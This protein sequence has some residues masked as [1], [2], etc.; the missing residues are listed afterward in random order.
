M[1]GRLQGKRI[2]ITGAGS[3]IGRAAV[4]RFAGEGAEILAIDVDGRGLGETGEAVGGLATCVADVSSLADMERVAQVAAQQ[5]GG[6]DGVYANAGIPAPGN[7]LEVSLKTWQRTLAVNL[8]GVWLTGRALLPLLIQAGGGSIVNQA[9]VGGVTGI[10]GIAAYAASKGGVVALTRSMAVDFASVKVRVNALCPAIVPTPLVDRNF[11]ERA[12]MRG[13]TTTVESVLE[14]QAAKIPL[15]RLG[16]VDDVTSL[17][18]FLLSD[19]ASWLTGQAI[20]LDGGM[21]VA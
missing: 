17:C 9:S 16:T 21:S 11:A 4:I 6:A 12:R 3:G 1:P 15:G 7:A 13:L 14:S 18:A 5:L 20:V 2:V 10:P 19:E 8:T